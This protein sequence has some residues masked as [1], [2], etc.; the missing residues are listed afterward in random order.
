MPNG[1]GRAA[2]SS[3]GKHAII[4]TANRTSGAWRYVE[5]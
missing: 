1:S 5:P 4:L 3:D 2:I